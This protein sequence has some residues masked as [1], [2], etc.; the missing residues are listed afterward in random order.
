MH[1][2]AP[3]VGM[4]IG[5]ATLGNS[6]EVPRKVK[7]RATVGPSDSTSGNVIEEYE[8]TDL[9][10]CL[11]PRVHCSIVYNGPRRGNKLNIH[12]RMNG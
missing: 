11:Q 9:K 2:D 1:D 6:T 12:Q 10:R 5:V 4:E 3:L 7:N 8:N